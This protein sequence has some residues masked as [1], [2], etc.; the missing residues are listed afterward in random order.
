MEEDE[1]ELISVPIAVFI[2]S[3]IAAL[4]WYFVSVLF[5]FVRHGMQLV[6]PGISYFLKSGVVFFLIIFTLFILQKVY[7]ADDDEF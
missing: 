7:G 1:F 5:L 3:T 6:L 2:L 4:I